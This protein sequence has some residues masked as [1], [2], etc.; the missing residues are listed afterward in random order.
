MSRK[1]CEYAEV[2]SVC[3]KWVVEYVSMM[4][5]VS[6]TDRLHGTRL[7]VR[8]PTS[9]AV[10]PSEAPLAPAPVVASFLGGAAPGARLPA[11]VPLTALLPA[12][13]PAPA[14]ATLLLQ[15]HP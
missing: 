14:P 2:A 5:G 6:K 13:V 9:L 11:P 7:T 3:H 4:K 1:C 10:P 15:H 8:D 12:P